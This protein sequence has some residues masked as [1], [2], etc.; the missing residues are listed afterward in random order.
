VRMVGLSS[1]QS[2]K[3]WETGHQRSIY[4]FVGKQ[5]RKLTTEVKNALQLH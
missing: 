4:G 1:L 5:S 3:A 2:V